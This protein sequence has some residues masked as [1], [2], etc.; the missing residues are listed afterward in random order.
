VNEQQILARDACRIVEAIGRDDSLI[1]DAIA[2]TR[3]FRDRETVA[4]RKWKGVT[5]A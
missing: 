5:G 1:E 4:R 2:K 3:I